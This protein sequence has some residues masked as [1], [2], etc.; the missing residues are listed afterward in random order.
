VTP[1]DGPHDA[2]L[3]RPARPQPLRARRGLTSRAAVSAGAPSLDVVDRVP[4]LGPACVALVALAM[5]VWTWRAWGDVIVDFGRELYVPWRLSEGQVLYRDIAYFNGPLS[6][7]WNALWFRVFGPSV[8]T[9]VGANLVVLAVLTGLLYAILS[10]IAGRLAATVAGIVFFPLFALGDFARNGSYTF[11]APYSHDLTHGVVLGIGGIFCVLRYLDGRRPA[12]VAGAGLTVGLLCLTKLETMLAGALA[13]LVGLV[14]AT[15]LE[16]P[17]AAR[18]IRLALAF[19]VGGVVPLAVTFVVFA[20]LTSPAEALRWPLGHWLTVSRG[21]IASL[22]FYREGLGIDNVAL[23]LTAFLRSTA[24]YAALLV[25]AALVALALRTPGPHRAG[26]AAA[27]L[28]ATVALIG[29]RWW[30]IAWLDIARPLPLTVAA[31]LL[32]WA[33]VLV[34]RRRAGPHDRTVLSLALGTFALVLLMKMVLNA[35]IYHYGF[36]LAMPAALLTIVALIA[37]VPALIDR[38][39]GDGRVFQAVVLGALLVT[40]LAHLSSVERQLR[41]KSTT[42][43]SGADTLVT[44]ARGA[45]IDRALQELWYRSRPGQ[46]LA[47]LP[48]GVMINYLARRH[49][50]TP[51]FVFVPVEMSL[52]GED[53]IIASF[54]ANPA[55]YV[56]LIHRETSE[57]GVQYFGRDYAQQL[58]AWIKKNYHQVAQIGAAPFTDGRFGIQLMQRNDLTP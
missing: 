32:G 7:Y 16:R 33:G 15:A 57:Y 17:P 21:E 39:G 18:V 28:I 26:M 43:G 53:R 22:P 25:P 24:W 6:P 44:D 27:L 5:L 10:R 31:I 42:V 3:K 40:V 34:V 49:N 54:A 12:W 23:S 55:D 41:F 35:R 46:T 14:S 11:L 29:V 37:W 19:V 4:W 8:L 38:R 52:Y 50:P 20:G 48:E 2:T 36:A 9:L 56:M 58:Y 45:A 13:I 47:V 30:R 1:P 51:Y